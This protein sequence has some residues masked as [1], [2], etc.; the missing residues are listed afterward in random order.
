MF[1]DLEDNVYRFLDKVEQYKP[2]PSQNTLY[3]ND[4]K[5]VRIKQHIHVDML[6]NFPNYLN[7]ILDLTIKVTKIISAAQ[8]S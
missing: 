4:P 8:P 3:G 5:I 2:L 7:G 1:F 6:T